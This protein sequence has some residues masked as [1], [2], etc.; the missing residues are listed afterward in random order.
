MERKPLEIYIHIP[1]C[2]RKCLYCDFLSGAYSKEEQENYV[3]SL[4]K[5]IEEGTDGAIDVNE[6]EIQSVF[7]GGG[8]PSILPANRITEILCKLEERFVFSEDAEITMEANP[9]TV[10]DEKA[11]EWFESGMNRISIGVQSLCDEELKA[12]G[13]IHG[14]EDF[15]K[16]WEMISKA[17]FR[18]RNIDLMSGIPGQTTASLEKTLQKVLALR[19][20]HISAYSLII[21]ED[22]FFAEKYPNG[23]VDE[24]TDREMYEL[25]GNLLKQKGYRR[26][27]ISNYALEGYECR[28]NLGYWKRTEYLG[29]G[30]GAASLFKE[31]RFRNTT[32]MKKYLERKELSEIREEISFLTKKEQM[33]ETMFLGLRMTDGVEVYR[34]LRKFGKT[35]FEV[36]P[37]AIDRHVR[38]GLLL[39]EKGRI[40]LTEKGMDLS[41]YVMADFC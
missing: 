15:Y 13:R 7:L 28:H 6:Y 17:G 39:S 11:G 32:S 2:I 18:N 33:S 10:T 21:E 4:L 5:E 8:T 12:L 26:Y 24:D 29:F 22:T 23:A 37:E 14:E 25:T 31:R 19:P 16:S 36:Y 35:P 38:E 40:R 20:E 34:F 3:N 27:E 30:I 1:F 9:G 41:N